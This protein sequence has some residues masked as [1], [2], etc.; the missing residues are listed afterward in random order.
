[1][2]GRN[3][4]PC[5]MHLVQTADLPHSLTGF[6]PDLRAFGFRATAGAAGTVSVTMQAQGESAA[7]THALPITALGDEWFGEFLSVTAFSNVTSI[8]VYLTDQFST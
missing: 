8:E 5:Q 3:I 7:T 1:M 6:K 4:V 2:I